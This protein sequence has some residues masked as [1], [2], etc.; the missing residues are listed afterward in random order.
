MFQSVEDGGAEKFAEGDFKAV[1]QLFDGYRAGI[2]AFAIEDAFDGGL[3]NGGDGGKLVG[4]D[5]ALVAEFQY[6]IGNGCSC[7]HS[8]PLPTIYHYYDKPN[9]TATLVII[10]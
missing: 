9:R 10:H 3:G 5:F 2:L 7:I 4:G 6:A 8:D 1:T